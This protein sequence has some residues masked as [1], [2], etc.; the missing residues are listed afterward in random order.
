MSLDSPDTKCKNVNT[1]INIE[2][3]PPQRDSFESLKKDAVRNII[4]FGKGKKSDVEKFVSE[5]F[6]TE[7]EGFVIGRPLFYYKL[8]HQGIMHFRGFE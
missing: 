3:N 5:N 1:I 7:E 2:Y 4:R 8:I 6:S